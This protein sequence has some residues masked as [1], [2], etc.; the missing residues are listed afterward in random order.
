MTASGV[1]S[2]HNV[3]VGNVFMG[4][5][6]SF[7]LFT[8]LGF[9]AQVLK[10][11]ES[12]CFGVGGSEY[13]AKPLYVAILDMA[14]SKKTLEEG[15]CEV[16]H[17][18]IEMVRWFQEYITPEKI[19][20]EDW[21]KIAKAFKDTQGS[22]TFWV[23]IVDALCR[24]PKPQNGR[25]Q[26]NANSTKPRCTR[27]QVQKLRV[28][29]GRIEIIHSQLDKLPQEHPAWQ[30]FSKCQKVLLCWRAVHFNR[31]RKIIRP[32]Q[33]SGAFSS[34]KKLDAGYPESPRQRQVYAIISQKE[35]SLPWH[36]CN[37]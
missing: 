25:L 5:P 12:F 22:Q 34:L 6:G 13:L 30:H 33:E 27:S 17:A 31:V 28:L 35:L 32:T 23:V 24:L 3:L 9:Q 11:Y 29:L 1:A 15:F 36:C 7:R 37:E 19:R 4:E 20:P 2:T 18:L 16:C 10:A 14:V 26:Q 21:P 8:E